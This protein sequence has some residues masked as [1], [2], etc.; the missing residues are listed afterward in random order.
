MFI[1]I[2]FPFYGH[3]FSTELPPPHTLFLWEI[4]NKVNKI[5]WILFVEL[6]GNVE[7][8]KCHT[9]NPFKEAGINW[10]LSTGHCKQEVSSCVSGFSRFP[11]LA[12]EQEV[13][14]A[15]EVMDQ[16]AQVCSPTV[17]SQIEPV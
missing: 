12:L 5:A 13:I 10:G 7:I 17:L 11:G 16:N 14:L 9:E 2:T 6:F 8:S 4:K 15:A 3:L 1:K